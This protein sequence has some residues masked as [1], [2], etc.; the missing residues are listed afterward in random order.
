VQQT[1][2]L[3]KTLANTIEV[4]QL[5]F[6]IP[7]DEE[8]KYVYTQFISFQ[9]NNCLKTIALP[10]SGLVQS[11]NSINKYYVLLSYPPQ[12]HHHRINKLEKK[13]EK[14]SWPAVRVGLGLVHAAMMRPCG[15]L[16]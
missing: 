8:G 13:K 1:L 16:V 12:H 7:H 10:L 11:Y 15:G 14:T 4:L 3:N 2:P 9:S 5:M 6:Q